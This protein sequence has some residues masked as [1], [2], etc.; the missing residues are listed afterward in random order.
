MKLS[1][2][3]W[4]FAFGPCAAV[5]KSIEEIAARLG[6]AGYDGIELSGYPPHVTLERYPS[7]ASRAALRSLLAG[8]GLEISGYCSDLGAHSPT[9]ASNTERYLDAFTRRVELCHDIGCPMIR[10]DTVAAP[11]AIPD[12]DYAGCFARLAELWRRCAERSS[13]AG[14]VMAWEFEPGFVFNKP[15]EIFELHRLIG[16]PGFRVMF[17]TGHAY[18]SAV[19]GAR[20]HAPRETL[21]RGVV[22]LIERLHDS[23]GFVHLVDSDGTLCADDTSTHVPLGHGRIDWAAVAP[24]LLTLPHIEWWCIDLSFCAQ[25]W[26][27]VDE[28]L[29]TARALLNGVQPG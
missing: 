1:M 22:E 18:M 23:I 5:P 14:V 8:H 2:G 7:A 6:G 9:I 25:A 17:D 27:L 16:H 24:K 29:R 4:S 19:G 10:V 3:S 12:A 13:A 11:G 26:E 21:Q 15:S 20:Q 28:S